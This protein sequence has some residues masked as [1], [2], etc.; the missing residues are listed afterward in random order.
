MER[1][2]SHEAKYFFRTTALTPT[3]LM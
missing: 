3:G 2:S 1:I